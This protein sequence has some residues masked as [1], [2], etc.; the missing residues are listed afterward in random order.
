MSR[1][2]ASALEELWTW[3]GV[4]YLALAVGF[5]VAGVWLWSAVD[6]GLAALA[7]MRA[8]HFASKK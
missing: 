6:A 3:V 7:L 5:T 4:L 8:R 2:T 1:S